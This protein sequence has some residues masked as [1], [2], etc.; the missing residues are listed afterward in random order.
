[1]LAYVSNTGLHACRFLV[2][3]FTNK[4][5]PERSDIDFLVEYKPEAERTF[6]SYFGLRGALEDI[7]GR[8]VDLVD[9]QTLRNPYFATNA[10]ITAREVYAA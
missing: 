6:A 5:D 9:V 8:P 2:R 4:F 3:F 1:M 7:V 10:L